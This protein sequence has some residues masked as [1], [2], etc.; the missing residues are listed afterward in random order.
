MYFQSQI[1]T[2]VKSES[3]IGVVQVV[4]EFEWKSGA[5]LVQFMMFTRLPWQ[6]MDMVDS[7]WLWVLQSRDLEV[8]SGLARY[9]LQI[10]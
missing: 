9:Q 7:S 2:W 10:D 1:K 3:G 5:G 6:E 8:S 4:L